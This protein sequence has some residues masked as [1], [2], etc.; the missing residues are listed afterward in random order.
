MHIRNPA[1]QRSL[2]GLAYVGP[3][4][5]YVTLEKMQNKQEKTI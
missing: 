1:S 2:Q 4:F 5:G 3:T